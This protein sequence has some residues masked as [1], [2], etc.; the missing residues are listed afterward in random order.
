MGAGLGG[1]YGGRSPVG[2]VCEWGG[3]PL[4]WGIHLV[5]VGP[6]LVLGSVAGVAE[7]FAAALMLTRVRLLASV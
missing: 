2:G 1:S 4:A 6:I 7:G 5:G 3:G